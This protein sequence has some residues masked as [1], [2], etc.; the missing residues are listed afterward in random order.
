M[1]PIV[2]ELMRES[3]ELAGQEVINNGNPKE[4]LFSQMWGVKF[5]ELIASHCINAI[6]KHKD[7]VPPQTSGG[8][9]LAQNIIQE[10]I[11]GTN[12]HTDSE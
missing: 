11:F 3:R 6:E 4:L 10:E 5:A 12:N 7:M 1:T 8:L 9:N 2:M